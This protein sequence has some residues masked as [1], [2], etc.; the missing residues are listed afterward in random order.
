MTTAKSKIKLW[1]PIHALTYTSGKTAWQVAC[2]VNG[3]RIRDTYPTKAEAE[4]RAAEIR[5]RV[6]NE[7]RA[8]FTM[9]AAVRAEASK[10]AE[11]LAPYSA[12]ITAVSYTHLTLPT[13]LRV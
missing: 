5:I 1:P 13:I 7:G 2:M 10:A 8:A 11:A 9:P 12:T 3:E 6:E 4:T